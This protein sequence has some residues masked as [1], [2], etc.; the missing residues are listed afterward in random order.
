[1]M[2]QTLLGRLIRTALEEDLG[3][4][5][6]VTSQALINPDQEARADINVKEPGV[7][8]GL[9]VFTAVMKAVDESLIV[10]WTVDEGAK[11][12]ARQIIGDVRGP[13]A[14]ILMAER[15]ALNFLGHMSGIATLTARF[16]AQCDGTPAVV[17]DTRKTLPGLREIEKYAVTIGGGQNH[18][19]GLY[20]G[21]LI[22]DNH[23]AACGS[24]SKAIKLVKEKYGA[25]ATIEVEASGLNQVK[26][27]REAGAEIIMLDNM[28]IED[29]RLA[30]D[31]LGSSVILEVSGGVTID[32]IRTIAA[33][34]VDR[35]SS[36]ALTMSAKSL[37]VS[38]DFRL[39]R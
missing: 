15:T 35:I 39:T 17:M 16:V 20:D 19:F 4:T 21:I 23:I 13:A 28:T 22:K 25:D 3:T 12:G 7:I 29:I 37:D 11:V 5:G 33:A 1:M 31:M 10:A 18:R 38:L 24:I 36:G 9:P 27:A 34:K 2:D 32:N 30:K 14:K 26:E 8:C 6:D